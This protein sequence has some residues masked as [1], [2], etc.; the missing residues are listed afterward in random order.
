MLFV[1][2]KFFFA[3]PDGR[4]PPSLNATFKRFRCLLLV[5]LVHL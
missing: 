2:D 3:A 1:K 5:D 4:L